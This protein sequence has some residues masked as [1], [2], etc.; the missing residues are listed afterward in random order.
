M[1][2]EP[3]VVTLLRML[4]PKNCGTATFS[5]PVPGIQVG[6]I[7]MT[8]LVGSIALAALTVALPSV[9]ALAKDGTPIEASIT[10]VFTRTLNSTNAAYC[11]TAI[12]PAAVAAN[13]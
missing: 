10:A 7:N 4:P 8:K 6:G 2:S 3:G 5:P 1:S 9:S 12:L 13:G 11:G